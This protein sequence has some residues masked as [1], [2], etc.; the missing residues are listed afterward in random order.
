MCLFGHM[1]PSLWNDIN[2]D[3][4]KGTGQAWKQEERLSLA[5]STLSLHFSLGDHGVVRGP[6]T[7]DS[8]FLLPIHWGTLGEAIEPLRASVLSPVK[9]DNRGA[10]HARQLRGLNET[11][12][13]KV[14]GMG[15]GA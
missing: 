13:V 7:R 5:P 12:P 14:P 1:C 8:E 4:S 10:N 6:Q 15:L 3:V 11:V 2:P 9:W